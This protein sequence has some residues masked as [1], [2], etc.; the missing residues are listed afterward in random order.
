MARLAHNTTGG[1][2]LAH[3][4]DLSKIANE[5]GIQFFL[6]CFVD[7]QGVL[8]SKMV[9]ASAIAEIQRDGAGFAPH[10]TYIDSGPQASDL[11]AIPDPSTLIQV[12]FMPELGFV[13]GNCYISG[14]K[15]QDSPRWVLQDQ[16]ARAAAH[17]YELMTGVEPEFF[18]LADKAAPEVADVKDTHAK[19]CYDAHALMRRYNLL[20]EVV[21]ALNDCG[22]GV[23]QI[24]HED[25]NGQFEINWHYADCL[26]TADRHVFFKWAL[27]TLAEKH[28]FKVTFMPK[29][30]ADLSG[31]G[32]H[33]HCSLWKG[34]RNLFVGD[35][36]CGDEVP[37]MRGLGISKLGL[38][39]MGG[40]L[41]K[42]LACCAI[43]NPTVNSYKRL[44]GSSRSGCTW[45]PNRVSCSGNNR[46]HM[47]RVPANDR[48]EV[49]VADG[50]VNPY[51]LPAVV[52]ASGLWGIDK[53]V[54]PAPYW[55]EPSV[56]LYTIP[57]G[58]ARVADL[59]VL[60]ANLLDA[61]R[62]LEGDADLREFLGSHF[63]G[64]FVKL[65]TSEW[66]DFMQHLS[67]WELRHTLDC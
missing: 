39:F 2:K 60:P 46:T 10:A 58:D 40:V 50:A 6:V 19:P 54:S 17:G 55:F 3:N 57:D 28:G 63:V 26:T 7:V 43:T 66:K 27:R 37:S 31:N 52:L 15:V 36:S 29:P 44:L 13:V 24:D 8:R 67:D 62:A 1:G 42:A 18:L 9:P 49:R 41:A 11:V 20:Q 48:F 53:A 56:N 21:K 33:C 14:Q 32:C 5:H 12:P 4:A 59:P 34:G 35:G 25:A 23:Y 61:L 22:F 51:L 65:R 16:I 64:S 30:F 38:H 47:V 45:A